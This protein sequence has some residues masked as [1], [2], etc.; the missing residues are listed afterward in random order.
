M[1]TSGILGNCAYSTEPLETGGSPEVLLRIRPY[2]QS[3]PVGS[4]PDCVRAAELAKSLRGR[5]RIGSRE[6]FLTPARAK[7]WRRLF[8]AGFHARRVVRGGAVVWLYSVG[9][10][11]PVALPVAMERANGNLALEGIA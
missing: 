6:W 2:V 7:K 11:A 3:G 5:S 10:D 4:T 9:N 1:N 8:L